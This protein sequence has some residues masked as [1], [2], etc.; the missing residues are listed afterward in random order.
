MERAC[1]F[2]LCVSNLGHNWMA[3]PC[4]ESKSTQRSQ[5]ALSYC[6]QQG[7]VDIHRRRSNKQTINAGASAGLRDYGCNND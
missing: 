7:R 6:L 4:A 1:V 2:P 5:K 3:D